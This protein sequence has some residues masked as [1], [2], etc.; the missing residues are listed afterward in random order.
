MRKW[1][2]LIFVLLFFVTL[3]FLL[4]FFRTYSYHDEIIR[5]NRDIASIEDKMQIKAGNWTH[6]LEQRMNRM[7]QSQDEYQ[8]STSERIRIIEESLKQSNII[9]K[10][11]N[12]NININNVTIK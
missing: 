4:L 7:A 11:T 3:S 1:R 12:K 10:N 9:S 6:Y 2:G 8:Y 5:L